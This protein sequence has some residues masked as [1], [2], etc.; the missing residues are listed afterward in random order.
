MN[1]TTFSSK[2]LTVFAN[3]TYGNIGYSTVIIYTAN[4]TSP[5]ITNVIASVLNTSAVMINWTTSVAS[6]TSVN[7]GLTEALGTTQSINDAVTAHSI[8]I[9][10]LLEGRTYYYNVTSR[11][12][13]NTTTVGAYSFDVLNYSVDIDY[14][15]YSDMPGTYARSEVYVGIGTSSI[16]FV[17]L[18]TRLYKDNVLVTSNFSTSTTTDII[19]TGLS[20]GNYSYNATAYDL[21]GRA[22]N[23]DNV[24]D[25]IL[26]FDISCSG[27]RNVICGLNGCTYNGQICLLYPIQ[28]TVV[29]I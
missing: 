26:S 8:T 6:N 12:A 27:L 2:N 11:T 19:F 10:N 15:L 1:F 21:L 22:Y 7:Y 20:P 28:N 24:E 3:D 5:N 13:S 18:T 25:I 29:I 17:N 16:G 23:L 4:S 14:I 9:N